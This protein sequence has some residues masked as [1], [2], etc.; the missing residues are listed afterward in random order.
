M[1]AAIRRPVSLRVRVLLGGGVVLDGRTHDLSTGG[2]GILL[3]R[4]LV[5]NSTVQVAIQLPNPKE[6]G[7]FDVITGSGKVVFQV[8]RG[9]DYQIGLQWMNLDSKTQ[10]L[11]QTFVNHISKTTPKI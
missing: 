9:D 8:L 6:P 11:L 3:Q 4:P 10:G 5:P 7:Q 1:R 2:V